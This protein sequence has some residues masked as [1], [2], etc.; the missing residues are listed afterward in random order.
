MVLG[1]V[2]FIENMNFF[3]K[4]L[5]IQYLYYQL[6]DNTINIKPLHFCRGLAILLYEHIRTIRL[7]PRNQR[8]TE[9]M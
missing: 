3:I 5:M 4:L 1:L 8:G 2:G 6:M 7:K 9:L